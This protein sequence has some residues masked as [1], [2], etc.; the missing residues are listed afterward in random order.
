VQG[1]VKNPSILCT[2]HA[3]KA[4]MQQVRQTIVAKEKYDGAC[5][6]LKS[7]LYVA[8]TWT[9]GHGLSVVDEKKGRF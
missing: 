8:A 1:S 3:I 6:V 4:W 9:A 2:F 5:T 7:I